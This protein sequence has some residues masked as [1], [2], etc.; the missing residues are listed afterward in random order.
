MSLKYQVFCTRTNGL[1]Y[2]AYHRHRA[3]HRIDGPA[4]MWSDGDTYWLHY[5]KKH[6][7]D[8]PAESYDGIHFY[9]INDIQYTKEEYYNDTK[10]RND[11]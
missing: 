10:I 1:R 7:L 11:S 3:V 4:A 2:I 9:Y 6:R 5:G 8:G